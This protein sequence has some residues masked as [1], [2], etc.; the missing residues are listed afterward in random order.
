MQGAAGQGDGEAQMSQ[1]EFILRVLKVFD[2]GDNSNL[3]WRMD[4]NYAPITFLANC[5]DCFWWATADCEP[6]TPENIEVLEASYR[7][8]KAA[9]DTVGTIYATELFAARVR[10]MRPQQPSYKHYGEKLKPLFDA[11]G[12]QR[13]RASEG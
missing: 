11:C 6:I 3:W 1:E 12:P 5:S 2:F 7:D 8:A 9:D 4:G 10:K 13:D